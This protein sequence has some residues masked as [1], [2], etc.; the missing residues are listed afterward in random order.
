MYGTLTNEALLSMA[1]LMDV[2][3]PLAQRDAEHTTFPK[4]GIICYVS[5]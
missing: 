2:F 5:N 1:A 3:T 4:Y